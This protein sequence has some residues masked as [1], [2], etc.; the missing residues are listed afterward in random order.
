MRATESTEDGVLQIRLTVSEEDKGRI[1]GKQ[2]KVIKA[3]R[4]VVQAAASAE[5]LR[6]MVEVD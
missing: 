3:I 5:N 2:G 1:I 4:T 6:T